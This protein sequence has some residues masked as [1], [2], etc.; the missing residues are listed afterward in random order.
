VSG[1][2]KVNAFHCG[3]LH[4]LHSWQWLLFWPAAACLWLYYRSLRLRPDEAARAAI[5]GCPSPRVI[6]MWHNR[7]LVGPWVL[8]RLF[9]ARRI[10]V[11]ISP[12][13]RAAWEVALFEW[14]GFRV[15]RG[16]SSRRGI[17][18]T[19]EMIAAARAGDDIAISPDGPVGPLYAVKRGTVMVARQA[20]AP[21]VFVGADSGWAV[22]LNTWD[23]HFV[24]LPFARVR[25]RCRVIEPERT[26][27]TDTGA[28]YGASADAAAAAR[29]RAEFLELTDDPFSIAATPEPHTEAQH[30]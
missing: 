2:G 3:T 23:R 18:S 28:D 19:R 22:R 5:A 26:T 8:S 27:A 11:L 9:D 24:P 16:S 12:S 25:I 6:V 20:R 7:S 17:Q 30:S 21:L 15:I 29:L 4:R 14:L 1:R 10:H 13:R